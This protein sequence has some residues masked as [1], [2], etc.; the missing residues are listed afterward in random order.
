[1]DSS[2]EAGY[3]G[4]KLDKAWARRVKEAD[5]WNAR[6]ADGSIKPGIGKRL[7][8]SIQAAAG[9]VIRGR[10]SEGFHE[11]M[12]DMEQHW[13]DVDGR[14]EASLAW[15]LNDTFGASFWLGG[16]FKV[17]SFLFLPFP[18]IFGLIFRGLRCLETPRS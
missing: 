8:W 13:R 3:L 15:A 7:K 4:D 2:R 1:M 10:K 18:E 6:L 17:H 16:F 9:R 5:D 11:R 14:K 12:Q